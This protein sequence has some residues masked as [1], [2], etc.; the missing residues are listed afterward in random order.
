MKPGS[1]SMMRTTGGGVADYMTIRIEDENAKRS[2]S[3]T[4]S[5]EQFALAITG[6]SHVPCQMHNHDAEGIRAELT[7]LRSLL[8]QHANRE[9]VSENG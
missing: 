3:A 7:R 2:V 9:G 5:M 1:I 6:M 4:M 8:E